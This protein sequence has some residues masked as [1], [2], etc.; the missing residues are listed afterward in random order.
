MLASS[1][2]LFWCHC[3]SNTKIVRCR[4]WRRRRDERGRRRK[5]RRRTPSLQ[6]AGLPSLV[7]TSMESTPYSPSFH[8]LLL[9]LKSD[10]F[11]LEENSSWETSSLLTVVVCV[12]TTV[13][14]VGVPTVVV[15]TVVVVVPTVVVVV[16]TVVVDVA[17]PFDSPHQLWETC[18]LVVVQS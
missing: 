11:T 1:P 3:L 17:H 12:P 4:A 13:F 10:V 8:T 9:L 15:P 6:L 14:F 5:K 18:L 7:H 2:M 16:L